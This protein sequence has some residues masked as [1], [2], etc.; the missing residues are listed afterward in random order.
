ME[1]NLKRYAVIGAVVLVVVC[2]AIAKMRGGNRYSPDEAGAESAEVREALEML[3]A[4]A[5]KPS[6][7]PDYMSADSSTQARDF[8]MDA[9]E[10]M[11]RAQSVE[12]KASTWFGDF[13]R[14]TVT[15]PR[16]GAKALEK[17]FYLKKVD[18]QMRITG[19]ETQ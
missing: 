1:F 9:A 14:V 7:T 3:R 13:L 10:L 16:D 8:V 15:C 12:H 19:M 6:T 17:T 11:S 2:V 18:G 5:Q 4:M